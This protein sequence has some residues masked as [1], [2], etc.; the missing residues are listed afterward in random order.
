MRNSTNIAAN[1]NLQVSFDAPTLAPRIF[2]DVKRNILSVI[3]NKFSKKNKS[4][5][6]LYLRQIVANNLHNMIEMFQFRIA[7]V[8]HDSIHVVFQWRCIYRCNKW[9]LMG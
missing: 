7:I 8:L 3:K 4:F 6:F 2:D 5:V 1:R 9:S